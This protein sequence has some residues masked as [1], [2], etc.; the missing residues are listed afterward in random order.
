MP[1]TVL[2]SGDMRKKRCNLCFHTA[3]S[4][5]VE[6][7]MQKK[8]CTIQY[9]KVLS[10]RHLQSAVGTWKRGKDTCPEK[11]GQHHRGGSHEAETQFAMWTGRQRERQVQRQRIPRWDFE[12][13]GYAVFLEPKVQWGGWQDE[14]DKQ[15]GVRSCR[16]F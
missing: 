8:I 14:L 2:S 1:G 15:V 10:W 12:G 3:Y 11:S 6:T 13:S 7:D 5:K 9:S 16:A 4:L